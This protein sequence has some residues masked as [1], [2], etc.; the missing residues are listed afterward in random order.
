MN[1]LAHATGVGEHSSTQISSLLFLLYSLAAYR[2]ETFAVKALLAL[3]QRDKNYS[4]ADHCAQIY[5]LQNSLQCCPQVPSVK[6]QGEKR[7]QI[8]CFTLVF[9][10]DKNEF[11]TSWMADEIMLE[12]FPEMWSGFLSQCSSLYSLNKQPNELFIYIT[13]TGRLCPQR[14]K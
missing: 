3:S 7:L 10:R 11:H 6:S 2:K 9:I 5:L 14:M 12:I 13:T 8:P 4:L 1:S